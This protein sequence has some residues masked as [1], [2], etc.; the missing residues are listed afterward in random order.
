MEADQPLPIE[1]AQRT[2][3]TDLVVFSA[4][5]TKLT[6]GLAGN[7]VAELAIGEFNVASK[8]TITIQIFLTK[9]SNDYGCLLLMVY[10]C[11]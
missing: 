4:S 11:I 1:F 6:G 3:T 9:A 8:A 10:K 5:A 2:V 7:G